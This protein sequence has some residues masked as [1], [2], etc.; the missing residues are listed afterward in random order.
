MLTYT[1]H[2]TLTPTVTGPSASVADVPTRRGWQAKDVIVAVDNFK[3]TTMTTAH[4]H[5]TTIMCVGT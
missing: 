4:N 5:N 3:T 2:L 1:Y